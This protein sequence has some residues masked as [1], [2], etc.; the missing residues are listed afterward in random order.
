MAI[1]EVLRQKR[2]ERQELKDQMQSRNSI[3]AFL[4]TAIAAR[5]KVVIK[6]EG[7]QN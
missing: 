4:R 1:D 7:L 3:K 5:E 2:L 6:L